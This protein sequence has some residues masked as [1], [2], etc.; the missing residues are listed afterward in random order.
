MSGLGFVS[1]PASIDRRPVDEIGRHRRQ[2]PGV[3]VD[4]RPRRVGQ[5]GRHVPHAGVCHSAGQPDQADATME[6]GGGE[7][8]GSVAATTT[9]CGSPGFTSGGPTVLGKA[10]AGVLSFGVSS[11]GWIERNSKSVKPTLANQSTPV[12]GLCN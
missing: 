9:P 2:D 5:I 8:C 11:D 3:Q 12:A 6:G 7:Y 4:A 10:S 1:Q